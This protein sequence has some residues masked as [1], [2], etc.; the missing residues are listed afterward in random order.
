MH[1][2]YFRRYFP[3]PFPLLRPYLPRHEPLA[4]ARPAISRSRPEGNSLQAAPGDAFAPSTRHEVDPGEQ[5]GLSSGLGPDVGELHFRM[6]SHRAD[7]GELFGLSTRHRAD[8][9]ELFASLT[10]YFCL[11]DCSA[12]RLLC[13]YASFSFSQPRGPETWPG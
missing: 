9:G 2:T 10:S 8:L 6:T 13:K 11:A 7:L 5:H 1:A 3:L 12:V 4:F